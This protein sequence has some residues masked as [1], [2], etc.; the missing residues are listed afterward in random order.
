MKK[1]IFTLLSGVLA[2]GAAQ[3]QT[4]TESTS[5][6]YIG[7]GTGAVK[8]SISRDYKRTTKLFGGYDFN[9]N[10]GVEAGYT[11]LGKTG[12]DVM[13]DTVDYSYDFSYVHMKSSSIYAAAKYTYPVNERG[14][15]YGKLGLAHT[16]YKFS[17]AEP[18]WNGKDSDNNGL[19]AAVG[20][21]YK[22]TPH[23]S[24]YTEFERNGKKA[25]NGPENKILSVGLK[26]GF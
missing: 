3:A 14:S 16:E 23:I 17:S 11:Y 4:V 24:M 5:H 10:W 6:A 20:L 18:G 22:L 12:F 21:Q 2:M 25:R 7:I 19:Y 1:T 15:V 26:Y 8:D 9:Q 13:R